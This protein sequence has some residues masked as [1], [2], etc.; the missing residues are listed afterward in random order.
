V[1]GIFLWLR[2]ADIKMP[3]VLRNVDVCKLVWKAPAYHSVMQI[4]TIRCMLA[5]MPLA[6]A[7]SEHELSMGALAK[8]AASQSPAAVERELEAARYEASLAGRR[9]E[10]VDTQ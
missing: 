5:L 4:F 10:L 9:N 6:G 8:A 3:V 7:H 2:S 1:R